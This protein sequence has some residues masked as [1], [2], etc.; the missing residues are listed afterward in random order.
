MKLNK[1]LTWLMLL[2]I[3]VMVLAQ[4]SGDV[5]RLSETG[6]DAGARAL[7]MGNA[8]TALSNDFNGALFNPA[9]LGL[10]KNFEITGSLN[11]NYFENKAT[12]FQSNMD[13]NTSN[14]KMN[15]FGAVFPLPTKRGSMVFSFGYNTIK[16]FNSA[17]E[18]DSYNSENHS[19]IQAL[20]GPDDISY[21]LYLTDHSGYNTPI[22]G[23]LNQYGNIIE[24]GRMGSWNIS[25]SVEVAQNIF[26]GATLNIYS[27][28]FKRDRQFYEEDIDNIYGDDVLTDPEDPETAGF[29]TFFMND[30][31]DWDIEGWDAKFGLL[32]KINEMSTVGLS[33]KSPSTFTI[34]ER[35]FLDAYSS[36]NTGLLVELD[37][38]ID[39]ALEYKITTPFEL[40][41]GH[42]LTIGPVLL[43][44]DL[45]F[46]DYS[47]M[48]MKEGL[49][50]SDESRINREINDL[51]DSVVKYNIGAEVKIPDSKIC[52]RA[53]FFSNPSPYK[54]DPSEFDKKYFTLGFGIGSQGPI[55][56]DFAYVRG[57]WKTYEDNYNYEEDYNFYAS[58]VFQDITTSNMILTVT[59]RLF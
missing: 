21:W 2:L 55:S 51:F 44:T 6:I 32:Y 23:N 33:V 50:L 40:A 3:N 25:G 19:M 18:F 53:G 9:G 11:Y 4:N 47:Q 35:F 46:V 42:A 45:T 14:F 29:E 27:G 12:L 13:Y 37:P 41:L 16:N 48:E 58:R 20:S 36:F 22:N 1:N 7:G 39:N 54:G 8:Y 26:I 24:S 30:I 57:W 59:Y 52:L 5:L 34:N 49:P 15:E 38:P 56:L 43:S 17:I 28:K 31:I 10:V